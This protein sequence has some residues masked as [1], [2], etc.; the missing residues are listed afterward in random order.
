MAP[1]LKKGDTRRDPDLENYSSSFRAKL[2]LKKSLR[3]EF[4][5]HVNAYGCFRQ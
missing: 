3:Q 5:L 4:L 1:A 2:G